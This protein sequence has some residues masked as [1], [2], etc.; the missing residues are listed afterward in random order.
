MN[1][2]P[3]HAV[4]MPTALIQMAASTVHVEKALKAMDS[5][6]KVKQLLKHQLLIWLLFFM[7]IDADIP[8]CERGL[9]NCGSNATCTNTFGSYNCGCNIG[10]T[11]DGFTCTG[12]QKRY[13]KIC[14]PL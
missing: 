9:D 3:I 8:E 1:W 11:G 5:T 14:T 10:F 7:P 6:V 4:P 12:Q 2:R 13:S